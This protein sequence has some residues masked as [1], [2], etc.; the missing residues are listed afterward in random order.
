VVIQ[1]VATAGKRKIVKVE[2]QIEGGEW[3][4]AQLVHGPSQLAWTQWYFTWTVPAPGV[5]SIAA[6]ATDDTGFV[7]TNTPGGLF[8]DAFPDGTDAIHQIS[9]QTA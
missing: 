9:L 2:I 7:Q 3:M 5:Y 4:P 6:R 1:G 8:G